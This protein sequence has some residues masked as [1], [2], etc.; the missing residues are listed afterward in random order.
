MDILRY[1]NKIS[2]KSFSWF[3]LLSSCIFLILCATYFQYDL[4]LAPCVLCVYERVAVF[5]IAFAATIGLIGNKKTPFRLGAIF[6]WILAAIYGISLCWEHHLY[7]RM[8]EQYSSCEIFTNFPSWLQLD[9]WF[10]SLFK[11][12]GDCGEIVLQLFNLSIPEMLL[13]I[14]SLFALTGIVVLISQ[15]IRLVPKDNFYNI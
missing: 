12:G 11:A 6:A 1:I 8:P 13:I 2:K 4:Q 15:F 9:Q 10:P 14:F 3:L 7:Q 5:A